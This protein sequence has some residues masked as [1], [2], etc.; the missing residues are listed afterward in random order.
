MLSKTVTR[1]NM[2]KHLG[3]CKDGLNLNTATKLYKL[4][5]RPVM[6]YA[7]PI[8]SYSSTQVDKYEKC[9]LKCLKA[10]IGLQHSGTKSAAV[11]LLAGIEPIK[12]RFDYLKLNYFQKIRLMDK[13]RLVHRVLAHRFGKSK[14]GLSNEVHSIMIDQS[15]P[16]EFRLTSSQPLSLFARFSKK[17]ILANYYKRDRLALQ[18]STSAWIFKELFFPS[19]TYLGAKPQSFGIRSKRSFP[20]DYG[21]AIEERKSKTGFL[22]ALL[23]KHPLHFMIDRDTGVCPKC[24]A[25]HSDIISHALL[26]C[27]KVQ[28]E[29]MKWITQLDNMKLDMSDQMNVTLKSILKQSVKPIRERSCRNSTILLVAFG[30]HTALKKNGTFTVTR[31]ERERLDVSDILSQR[32]AQFLHEVHNKFKN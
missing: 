24:G 3:M 19:G 14:S 2:V 1:M 28:Q 31:K 16:H 4:L 10:L 21:K 18:K 23:G 9:Q 26:D 20:R 30:G 6:E 13:D 29:R 15:M 5:V 17:V 12:S 11:R 32:S 25:H 7:A 22:Q 8:L 27:P